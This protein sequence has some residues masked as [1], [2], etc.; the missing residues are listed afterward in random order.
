V[1]G[2][3]LVVSS[4]RY[5]FPYIKGTKL[6]REISAK[7]VWMVNDIDNGVEVRWLPVPRSIE[8][9]VIARRAK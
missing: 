9:G 1:K 4:H 2:M 5:I 6:D 7:D 3:R 8:V